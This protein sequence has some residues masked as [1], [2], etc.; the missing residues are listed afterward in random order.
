MPISPLQVNDSCCLPGP[1]TPST[2]FLVESIN[3]LDKKRKEEKTASTMRDRQNFTLRECS[4]W[5]L[6]VSK[7]KSVLLLVQRK[8]VV[9][10]NRCWRLTVYRVPGIWSY[11]DTNFASSIWGLSLFARFFS[12]GHGPGLSTIN[13]SEQTFWNSV[14]VKLLVHP[15]DLMRQVAAFRSVLTTA[16]HG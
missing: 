4:L 13:S 16:Q 11:Y 9:T 8:R 5:E 15:Q 2:S 12:R 3:W 7:K 1:N 14:A 10:K 6:T